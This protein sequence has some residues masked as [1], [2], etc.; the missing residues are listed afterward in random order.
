MDSSTNMC[1]LSTSCD[2]E[3]LCQLEEKEPPLNSMPAVP[4]THMF[5]APLDCKLL[6][7]KNWDLIH[8][9]V[10]SGPSTVWHNMKCYA[11]KVWPC[12]WN[13]QHYTLFIGSQRYYFFSLMYLKKYS[14]KLSDQCNQSYS[15]FQNLRYTQ[16]KGGVLSCVRYY[17]TLFGAL[18]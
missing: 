1:V 15:H 6:E 2:S 3:S 11:K 12:E 17:L 14:E 13:A 7:H 16:F 10:F 8:P 18:W 4:F 5:S 9:C